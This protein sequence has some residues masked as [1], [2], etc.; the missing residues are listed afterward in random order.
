VEIFK[1]SPAQKAH[2]V[3]HHGVIPIM[4]MLEV[5]N[6]EVL[7]AILQVVNQVCK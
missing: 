7:H 1:E 3:T 5:S 4:E 2:L 6:P